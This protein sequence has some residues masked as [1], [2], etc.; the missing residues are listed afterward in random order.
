VSLTF[1]PVDLTELQDEGVLMAA[2]EAFFWPLG[3]A[4]T[5]MH[6]ADGT[7][8]G[9]H[10]RQWSHLDGERERIDLADDDE[11]GHE[12]R[13]RFEEWRGRRVASMLPS[14]RPGGGQE[15]AGR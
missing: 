10:V 7:A 2:N 13:E 11:Q 4:L 12:R 6:G 9:L 15:G 8:T 3:L 5:W 1:D 14:E